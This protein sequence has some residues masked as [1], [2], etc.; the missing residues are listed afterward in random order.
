ML[1]TDTPTAA[2]A[3]DLIKDVT[4]ATFMQ[5]V[6]DASNDVPVIV[7]FWAPWCGPCKTLGPVLEA[8]VAAQGGRVKMAKVD[9]DQNQMIAQQM[10]VQSIPAVFA[11]IGG[12]PVDGFMGNKT[13]AEIETFV[14]SIADQGGVEAEG[15]G[16]AAALEAADEMLEA[17]EAADAAET[18]AAILAE[19]PENMEAL[20]G[21]ARA[22]IALGQLDI[23]TQI[24]G[25]VPPEKSDIQSIAAARAQLE[26]AE[27]AQGAG[28]MGEMEAAV[29][30][31][32]DNHQ[33]RLDLAMALA[34]DNKTEAAIDHLLELFR[35]DREW[36]DGAAKAQLFKLLDLLGPQDP[37]A[38]KSRRRLSSMIFA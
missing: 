29:E 30:K 36:N 6:V 11:F 34:A 5:D 16:L 35:R 25:T 4:E 14:K 26:L 21:M 8:A 13:P 37:L 12:R 3:D 18:Y 17:G 23:A 1:G 28:E 9:V 31:E 33:A 10:R 24:L 32:P 20:A 7:D 15:G 27:V 2:V 19:D 38:L 22:N